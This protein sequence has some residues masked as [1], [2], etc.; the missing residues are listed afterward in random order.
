MTW[1]RFAGRPGK[2]FRICDVNN[3]LEWWLFQSNG[4]SNIAYLPQ[5]GMRIHCT[6]DSLCFENAIGTWLA[7]INFFIAPKV[8]DE[9]RGD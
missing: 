1:S 3:Y 4:E 6:S 9:Q 2:V 5:V 8:F 7:T